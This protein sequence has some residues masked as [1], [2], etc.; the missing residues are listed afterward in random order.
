MIEGLKIDVPSA[1]LVSLY[2]KRTAS[3]RERAEECKKLIGQAE[4]QRAAFGAQFNMG[5][6]TP[7][8]P[9]LPYPNDALRFVDPVETL[10]RRL[11][12]HEAQA[13]YCAFL[14]AHII[15]NETYRLH[16]DS[17]MGHYGIIGGGGAME[18]LPLDPQPG[19]IDDALSLA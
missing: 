9:G 15:P 19:E 3:C 1:E 16:L 2:E 17:S 4:L 7:R 5:H 12:M 10:R 8:V 13:T 6:V 18:A 11:K 14:A